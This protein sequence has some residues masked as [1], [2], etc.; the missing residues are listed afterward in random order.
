MK[1]KTKTV[2]LT[3]RLR[4]I[5]EKLS[6][7]TGRSMRSLLEAAL[8]KE[9]GTKDPTT[10]DPTLAALAQILGQDVSDLFGLVAKQADTTPKDALREAFRLYVRPILERYLMILKNPDLGIQGRTKDFLE[11]VKPIGERLGSGFLC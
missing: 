3:P 5:L 11:A 4:E 7:Q 10:N 8:D 1:E 2:S 6:A 9:F